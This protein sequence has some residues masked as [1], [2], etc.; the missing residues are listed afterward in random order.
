MEEQWWERVAAKLEKWT[1]GVF[2]FIKKMFDPAVFVGNRDRVRKP[3]EPDEDDKRLVELNRTWRTMLKEDP[4]MQTLEPHKRLCAG[5][6]GAF[7]FSFV[8]IVLQQLLPVKHPLLSWLIAGACATLFF[9]GLLFIARWKNQIEDK[10][11]EE[12]KK[13]FGKHF[14]KR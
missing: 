5:I 9:Y 3:D 10:V 13:K 7:F 8:V 4:W 6:I 11:F 2:Q 14:H 1:S 12:F